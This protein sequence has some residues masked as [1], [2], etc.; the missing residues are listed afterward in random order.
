MR[1]SY[2]GFGMLRSL[3]VAAAVGAAALVVSLSSSQVQA[4]QAFIVPGARVAIVGDSI[5]EQKLYSKYMEA[6]LL[7]CLLGRERR[8]RLPIRLEWRAGA[9]L[10]GQT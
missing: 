3:G 5:T 6:Y 9:G 4:Q 10:C 8:E 2:L 1:R 7:A